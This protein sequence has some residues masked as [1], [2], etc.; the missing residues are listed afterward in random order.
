[1]KNVFVLFLIGV[2][3]LPSC[4]KG[5]EDPLLSLR[6]RKNR[7][8]GKWKVT[9]G[10]IEL[11]EKTGSSTNLYYK[12]NLGE[13][14]AH[15]YAS[16][17]NAWEYGYGNA[18]MSFSEKFEFKKDGRF[19]HFLSFDADTWTEEGEWNFTDG[20]GKDRKN[21]S[22]LLL[23]YQESTTSFYGTETWSGEINSLVY[24]IVGLRNNKIIIRIDFKYEDKTDG[25]YRY[26][27]EY[28]VLE[29]DK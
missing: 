16:I 5:E 2:I 21:K 1:M 11:T 29:K 26:F 15:L 3:L 20:I 19:T 9:E 8:T 22:E 6:S 13:T 14:S 24:D 7:L 18:Y 4:R 23:M 10:F 17:S 28:K 27:T 25:F 12:V